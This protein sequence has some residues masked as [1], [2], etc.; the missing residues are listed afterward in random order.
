MTAFLTKFFKNLGCSHC[1]EYE[2]EN[3]NDNNFK[4]WKLYLKEYEMYSAMILYN[5][6]IKKDISYIIKKNEAIFL[7]NDNGDI[8]IKLEYIANNESDNMP[9]LVATD[10]YQEIYESIGNMEKKYDKIFKA[11]LIGTYNIRK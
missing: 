8:Y 7:L 1:Q 5:D 2:F 11:Y 10:E 4:E 9:I 3:T 6:N